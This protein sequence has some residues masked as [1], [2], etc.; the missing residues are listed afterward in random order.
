MTCFYVLK[1]FETEVK[2]IDQYFNLH[3]VDPNNYF[4]QNVIKQERKETEKVFRVDRCCYCDNSLFNY[5]LRNMHNFIKHYELGKEEPFENKLLVIETI[6]NVPF[7]KINFGVY[8]AYYNLFNSDIVNQ[9]L[10]N[11]HSNLFLDL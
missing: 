8:S 5:R 4:F 2:L 10:N 6:G 7:Y 1:S 11:V 3:N 9:S